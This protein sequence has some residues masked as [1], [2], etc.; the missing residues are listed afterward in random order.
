M[1]WFNGTTGSKS[2]FTNFCIWVYQFISLMNS[3]DKKL[4]PR[5]FL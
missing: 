5:D 2:K 3:Q 4:S 1:K